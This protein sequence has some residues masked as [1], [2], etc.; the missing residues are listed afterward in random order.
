MITLIRL[1]GRAGWSRPS[2]DIYA[3]RHFFAWRGPR[4]TGFCG[5]R[6]ADDIAGIASEK[7]EVKALAGHL[8][9]TTKAYKM[10]LGPEKTKVTTNNSDESELDMRMNGTRLKTVQGF[11]YF[12]SV[13]NDDGSNSGISIRKAQT[14]EAL[15]KLKDTLRKHAYSNILKIS[16]P[17][18]ESFQIKNTDIFHISA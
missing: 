1:R 8:D 6:F 2:L 16:P 14:T 12:G 4:F 7:N 17:K 10:E 3:R 18:T 9:I 15:A 13:I 5:I 11:K